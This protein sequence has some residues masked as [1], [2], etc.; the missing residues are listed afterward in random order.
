MVSNYDPLPFIAVQAGDEGID[1][2]I[3][4]GWHCFKRPNTCIS[5]RAITV[6]RFVCQLLYDIRDEVGALREAQG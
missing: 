2:F 4:K 6:G 1:R 5:N 3:R